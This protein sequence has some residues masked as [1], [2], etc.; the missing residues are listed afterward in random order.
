MSP[1]FTPNQHFEFVLPPVLGLQLG[2]VSAKDE[3]TV[4]EIRYA[5]RSAGIE[6]SLFSIDPTTGVLSLATNNATDFKTNKYEVAIMASDGVHTAH[7]TVLVDVVD[8]ARGLT[9]KN[10]RF[11]KSEYKISVVENMTLDRAEVLLSFIVLNTE[12]GEGV[13][14]RLLNPM[15]HF[16]LRENTGILELASGEVLDR[17]A[18][19]RIELAIEVDYYFFQTTYRTFR[20]GR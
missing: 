17:E 12:F 18:N 6:K 19:S 15:P 13:K 14:Y 7:S 3:D 4:G 2:A 16:R 1:I 5:I 20:R 9:S 11:S 10:L 8:G